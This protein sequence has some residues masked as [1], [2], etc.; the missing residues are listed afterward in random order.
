M[1][2][3]PERDG[4]VQGADPE[5]DWTGLDNSGSGFTQACRHPATRVERLPERPPHHARLTLR[6]LRS[7]PTLVA[8]A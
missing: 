7:L 8:A 4:A 6:P 1:K 5:T 3:P 2:S